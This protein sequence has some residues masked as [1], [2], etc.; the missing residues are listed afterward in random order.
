MLYHFF[1]YFF[2]IV[3]IILVIF[4]LSLQFCSFNLLFQGLY[5]CCFLVF[6]FAVLEFLCLIFFVY[7]FAIYVYKDL[8][9]GSNQFCRPEDIHLF[10][11]IC[12]FIHILFCFLFCYTVDHQYLD[13]QLIVVYSFSIV[14]GLILFLC[15]DFQCYLN[16]CQFILVFRASFV[17]I[18]RMLEVLSI[19]QT[20]SADITTWE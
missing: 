1:Y 6:C 15:K 16:S 9:Y 4:L 10:Y 13:K 11:F 2:S 8:V 5:C 18:D 12:I 3:Y 20:A 19:F 17:A 7:Y 14:F